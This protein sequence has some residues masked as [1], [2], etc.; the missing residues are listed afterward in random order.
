MGTYEQE[1]GR[2][3][4]NL[5]NARANATD[6][7]P[8]SEEQQEWVNTAIQIEDLLA[9]LEIRRRTGDVW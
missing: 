3:E 5:A 6:A 2:L 7:E 8:G 4:D 1:K 9:D